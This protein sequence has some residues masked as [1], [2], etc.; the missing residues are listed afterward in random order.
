MEEKGKDNTEFSVYQSTRCL[1]KGYRDMVWEAEL[2]AR[3]L[4][5]QF[6]VSYEGDW[7][8]AL[9]GLHLEGAASADKAVGEQMERLRDI[10]RTQKC[11]REALEVLRARHKNGEL[12]YWMLYYSYLSPQQFSNLEEI[13]EALHTR[14]R[15]LSPRTYYRRRREAV[16][17]LGEVM[18]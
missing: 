3:Q 17:A 7:K 13:L 8:E 15:E 6:G 5:R 11:L 2:T 9:E 16:T 14:M 4:C 10:C 18:R 1:L 12:Y